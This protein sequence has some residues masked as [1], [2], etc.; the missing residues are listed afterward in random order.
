MKEI[1]ILKSVLASNFQYEFYE[2]AIKNAKEEVNAN[3]YY[4]ENWNDVIKL[5]IYRKL[6]E[7]QS[8]KLINDT[9]NLVLYENSD[10]EAYRWLDLFLI[11]IAKIDDVV[12]SY[13][14]D[15]NL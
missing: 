10:E 13:Q 6:D 9:A 14:I 5:I 12:I 11:N 7:G 4:K 8:L 1:E 2:N 15:K 3:T